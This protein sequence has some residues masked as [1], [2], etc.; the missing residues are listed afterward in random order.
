LQTQ[1]KITDKDFWE[2]FWN[3]VVLPVNVDY[4]F[5]NDR[6]I[7]RT[8][9]KYIPNGETIKTAIEI[10]CAPGKWLVFFNKELNYHVTGVEYLETATRKTIENMNI[11]K[12]PSE[13]YNIISCDFFDFNSMK[14]YDVVF[15]LGFIEH[16][17]DWEKV[18]DKHIDLCS[19]GEYVIIGFP[20]FHGINYIF[21][22]QIDKY[23]KDPLIPNHNLSMMNLKL[24]KKY[25]EK[26]GLS[27]YFG[28]LVG[29]FE[30]SLFNTHAVGNKMLRILLKGGVF[31]SSLFF[32]HLNTKYTASYIMFIFK[33]K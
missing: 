3:T 14:K 30:R 2:N 32:G 31:L 24:F 27:L 21:Q 25:A 15:S 4:K 9:K 28:N 19:D 13:Q 8:I 29:G 26:R 16:F 6:I 11:S 10:G 5:K 22:K 7:A 18:L 12:V 23:L 33:K 1:N 20:N 17:T